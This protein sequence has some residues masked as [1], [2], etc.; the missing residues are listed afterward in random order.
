M[1]A[2]MV[3]MVADGMYGHV[4]VQEA[5]EYD[6]G[7]YAA[8]LLRHSSVAP[9]APQQR[10][11][12]VSAATLNFTGRVAQLHLLATLPEERGKGYARQLLRSVEGLAAALGMAH[13]VT[14]PRR[15]MLDKYV[16]SWGYSVAT[17]AEAAALHMAVPLAYYDCAVVQKRLDV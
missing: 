17:P 4:C 12:P 6:H 9:G 2:C 8:L 7:K 1:H 5:R 14:Q 13:M 3:C 16:Q 10:L 15:K 11:T